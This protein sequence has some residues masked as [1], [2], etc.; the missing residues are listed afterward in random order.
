MV[1][2]L[3]SASLIIAIAFWIPVS[4]AHSRQFPR[5]GHIARSPILPDQRGG[6]GGNGRSRPDQAP[7]RI[8]DGNGGYN[9]SEQWS[10]SNTGDRAEY[11]YPEAAA[12]SVNPPLAYVSMNQLE[13]H[14]DPVF[15]AQ[16]P[17]TY[18]NSPF[19]E[20]WYNRPFEQNFEHPPSDQR[21]T[22][23]PGPAHPALAP[24][25]PAQDALAREAPQ[26]AAARVSRPKASYSEMKDYV[27]TVEQI[28][29]THGTHG[30]WQR[31]QKTVD[32]H[33]NVPKLQM[34]YK[35]YKASLAH[36]DQIEA[37]SQA[38]SAQAQAITREALSQQQDPT[39]PAQ[40]Y[41][42][43]SHSGY[44]PPEDFG[45]FPESQGGSGPYQQKRTFEVADPG[46]KRT[47][48][49]DQV[50]KDRDILGTIFNTAKNTTA[51][52]SNAA[53]QYQSFLNEYISLQ[54]HLSDLTYP[55]IT[56]V[57]AS[58]AAGSAN[59]TID[60]A[61]IHNIAMGA[62]A[63]IVARPIAISGPFMFGFNCL[64]W[65]QESYFNG[66]NSSIATIAAKS[67]ITDDDLQT[68]EF[69]AT[70]EKLG[71]VYDAAWRNG[72][73]AANATG[74]LDVFWA[75]QGRLMA[76]DTGIIPPHFG[77][78]AKTNMID[79]LFFNGGNVSRVSFS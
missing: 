57:I 18:L 41:F 37:T 1:S 28:R 74:A 52:K 43:Q 79:Q 68:L 71:Q 67:N 14:N 5:R 25:Y 78:V 26:Q 33:A 31:V 24:R 44:Y 72:T 2:L 39:M 20:A 9:P 54:S 27:A 10:G 73:A 63:E 47:E 77:E 6:Y 48:P 38:Q 21:G 23:A 15:T 46:R 12:Y 76:N 60:Y 70:Y 42:D 4:N 29:R 11:P 64:D 69:F 22:E 45:P 8:Y 19:D 35:R 13:L 16:L 17:R 40:W 49:S 59:N 58:H 53:A 66:T 56:S 34:R 3:I 61:L 65:L 32:P 36:L 50:L 30:S 75:L 62:Y 51:A 7:P 55:V